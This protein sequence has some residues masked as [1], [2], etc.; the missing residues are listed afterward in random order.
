MVVVNQLL[1]G[2]SLDE[3]LASVSLLTMFMV[4]AISLVDKECFDGQNS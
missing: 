3:Q 4:V 2:G 1:V